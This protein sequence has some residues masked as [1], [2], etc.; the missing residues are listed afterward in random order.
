LVARNKIISGKAHLVIIAIEG[1][2]GV[3]KGTQSSILYDNLIKHG[4]SASLV[5]FPVYTSFF[6]K[7][8]AEYL[9]GCYGSLKEIHPKLIANLYAF[10]RWLYF[11]EQQSKGID[12]I[13]IDRYVPSNFAHQ[14]SKFDDSTQIA[15]MIEWIKELEHE[16]LGQPQPDLVL[17]LDAPVSLASSQVLKKAER[18]YTNLK[19]DLHEGD[20]PYLE[21]VRNVFLNLCK[22][23][24]N[25]KLV[26]CI[27]ADKMRSIDDISSEI[28]SFVRTFFSL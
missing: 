23:N 15:Q 9:N 1:I 24:E 5:S 11:K 13:V 22:S 26:N 25:Y 3:G 18:S 2:D 28:W 12:F 10:D 7:M 8:V 19:K 17:V 27:D 6:G 14:A 4:L 16:I 20:K 21:N